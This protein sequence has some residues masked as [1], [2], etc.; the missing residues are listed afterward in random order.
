MGRGFRVVDYFS[1]LRI[2]QIFLKSSCARSD[3]E[4]THPLGPA[5]LFSFTESH[6]EWGPRLVHGLHRGSICS[7]PAHLPAQAQLPSLRQQ[8]TWGWD[9]QRT[10]QLEVGGLGALVFSTVQWRGPPGLCGGKGA[11]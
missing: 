1:F 2:P 10:A 3:S 9:V 6:G 8:R 5:Q 4:L 11:S 7:V